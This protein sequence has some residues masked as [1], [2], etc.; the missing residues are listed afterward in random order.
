MGLIV[1]DNSKEEMKK[2]MDII[3]KYNK[4][5]GQESEYELIGVDKDSDGGLILKLR[6]IAL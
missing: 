1:D 3:E 5:E 6:K 4:A 2:W